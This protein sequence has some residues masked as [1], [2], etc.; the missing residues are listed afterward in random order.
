MAPKTKKDKTKADLQKDLATKDKELAKALAEADKLKKAAAK[1][2]AQPEQS[3]TS[4]DDDVEDRAPKMEA[5]KA[6]FQGDAAEWRGW[7]RT[8]DLWYNVRKKHASSKMLGAL[9]MESV[10]GTARDLVYSHLAEGKESFKRVLKCLSEEYELDE[11]LRTTDA[12]N[13]LR[14]CRRA[15]GV[16]LGQHLKT[17][18]SLRLEAIKHG[19]T[20]SNVDGVDLL[21]SCDL[22][23][24]T[25]TNVLIQL[26]AAA[27]SAG[28]KKV[29]GT[30]SG[31][32]YT[33]VRSLLR[34][35]A[36]AEELKARERESKAER[37]GGATASR[38][39]SASVFV[40]EQGPG[41]GSWQ[42]AAKRLKGEKGKGSK[43]KSKGAGKKGAAKGVC[44][45]FVE[46]RCTYGDSCR[47][48]HPAVGVAKA[49]LFGAK[50]GKK[51]D[52]SRFLPGDW[53][54]PKCGAHN[55]AKQE[56]CFKKEC[57]APREGRKGAGKG[58]GASHK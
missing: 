38:K 11:V 52:A 26:G 56:Q 53:Q 8:V 45:F 13:A 51:G 48:S 28:G 18:H 1:F 14:E 16:A 41:K 22:A 6:T 43:G 32:T 12:L 19:F 10:Q 49:A 9:L 42:G 15:G 24:Q 50:A 4:D 30:P 21:A 27:G 17:Y 40:A 29:S 55:F 31:L 54:C 3:E 20:E 47:F 58:A 7:R 25:H 46:G 37:E 35:I 33:E 5:P 2:K 34:T 36:K 44:Q 23:P 39:R 57:G